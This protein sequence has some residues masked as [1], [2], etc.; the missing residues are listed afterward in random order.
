MHTPGSNARRLVAGA[1]VIPG[2]SPALGAV[3]RSIVGAIEATPTVNVSVS[4][5]PARS[6]VSSPVSR[7][8][9]V[10]L[11]PLGTDAATVTGTVR[12]V[13]ENAASSGSGFGAPIV[14]PGTELVAL[15][16]T[17]SAA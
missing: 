13:V 3:T 9:S 15:S 14:T 17:C 4:V 7:R 5:M 1:L 10:T 8:V 6:Q 11:V 16:V 2:S 12:S